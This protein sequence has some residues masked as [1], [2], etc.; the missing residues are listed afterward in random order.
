MAAN[1][2]KFKVDGILYSKNTRKVQGKKD[3]SKT[4]EF[5]SFILEMKNS[6]TYKDKDSG[7]DRYGERNELFQFDA[8]QKVDLDGF[9]IGD[10]ITVSFE[11]RGKEY[12]GRNGGG[13]VVFSK[14]YAYKVEFAALDAK[15]PDHKGKV[16][17]EAMSST[18]E[19]DFP[20]MDDDFNN[21]NLPF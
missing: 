10:V 6:Y 2:N 21:D 11:L 1:E 8:G 3:P 18:A 9:S 4:F 12:P 13:K 14:G 7:A 19:L 20:G 17:V 16:T 15:R 5:H